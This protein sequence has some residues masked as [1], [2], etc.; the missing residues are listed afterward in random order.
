LV[1]TIDYFG[2]AKKEDGKRA[3]RLNG[4]MAKGQLPSCHLAPLPLCPSRY[5]QSI[6]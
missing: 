1:V 4:K 2:F 5:K 3:K 6:I